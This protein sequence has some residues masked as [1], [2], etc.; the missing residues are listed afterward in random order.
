MN[1]ENIEKK[2]VD[3]KPKSPENINQGVILP[4]IHKLFIQGLKPT[5]RDYYDKLDDALFDLA[6]KA[7]N[8]EKQNHYFE[9]MREV[10]KKKEL[11]VRK[12]SEN[13]QQV[14]KLFKQGNFNYFKTPRSEETLDEDHLSLVDER[15][16][17]QKLAI[18]NL[19]DKANSY[20]H[21]HLFALE[22]RFTLLAGGTEIKINQIPVSPEIIVDSF[23][24]TFDHLNIDDTMYIIMLKLFE[25]SLIH[26]LVK[27]Y[28]DINQLLIESGII[29]NLKFRV[30]NHGQSN[31]YSSQNHTIPNDELVDQLVPVESQQQSSDSVLDAQYQA[32]TTALSQRHVQSHASDQPNGTHAA[33]GNMSMFDASIVSNALSI[34]QVEEL[35]NFNSKQASLSPTEIKNALLSRLKDLDHEGENKQV[36]QQ[37]EDIIDLV[38]MLFQFL[39]DDRNLPDRIQALLAKLQIPY[40]HLALKDRKLFANKNDNARKLLDIIAKASIGWNE[41]D[42]KRGKFIS[43]IEEIV[44]NILET[45]QHGI[46]FPAMIAD[47]EEF[48]AKNS[49]RTKVIEKR[50]SEKA[51]GQER[52]IKAKEQTAQI[53]E[54][55]LKKHSLPKLVTEL[56][57]TPWA[58]VLILAHLRHQDEP[59]KIQNFIKFVDKLIFVSVKNKKNM[60][61]NAQISHVCDQLNQG[62]RL[63]AFDEHS[64]KEKSHE[65]YHLLMSI[66]GIK[67]ADDVNHEMMLPQE[68]FEVDE[69]TETE[70]PEIVHFIADKKFNNLNTNITHVDDE[71]YQQAKALETGEW[72][73]FIAEEENPD[74]IEKN[75]GVRAKLS[76]ISPISNKLLFVN[77]RGVKV[78][79]KSLDEL[80]HDLREKQAIVLQQIPLF[81]RAMSSIA[82]QVTSENEKTKQEHS[83]TKITNAKTT[84][85]NIPEN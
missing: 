83:E 76:W 64:I 23:A 16:L 8:N 38:G 36:N 41:E 62:L 56:L 77:A 71:Y 35:N 54:S 69:S 66:N 59:K 3:I 18:S 63:V 17:D 70:Q 52:I 74:D 13:V 50:T 67:E 81:D 19:I 22:K 49:K 11:M 39:V 47:F 80:A 24:A 42:D 32:I 79:D 21:Q 53:L 46:D 29:P 25:R 14:F 60:A 20:L 12:F 43:K 2:I 40:L 75:E 28:Q 33:I 84:E 15:E 68:V 27:T 55:K 72:I 6:E 4:K 58:N 34:L 5:I 10:R 37:D 31:N 30:T 57:L 51:L 26:N 9:A 61:T 7:E 1:P 85:N 78:T 48:E 73:Q 65:L 44:Q 45:E 82:Q